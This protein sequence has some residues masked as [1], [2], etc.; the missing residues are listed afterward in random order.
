MHCLGGLE[1]GGG[2]QV[3]ALP[4][5]SA[6][7]DGEPSPEAGPGSLPETRGVWQLTISQAYKDCSGEE[8]TPDLLQEKLQGQ[9]PVCR[10]V[11][12]PPAS[13][14]QSPAELHRLH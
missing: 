2:S 13:R 12:L 14:S 10:L 5:S 3:R 9:H 4:A 11:E 7:R 8:L 6:R 1:N